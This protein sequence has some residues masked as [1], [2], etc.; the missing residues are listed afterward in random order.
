MLCWVYATVDRANEEMG[1]LGF[2]NIGLPE[3]VCMKVVVTEEVTEVVTDYCLPVAEYGVIWH[4]LLC[5]SD[6]LE[7][8]E[9]AVLGERDDSDMECSRSKALEQRRR[10]REDL[11]DGSRGVRNNL[12]YARI[13]DFVL[14]ACTY[15]AFQYIQY[16]SLY[17][18]KT[19]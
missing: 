9:E 6:E 15:S 19:L 10:R 11:L 1:W 14:Y 16:Y 7:S 5:G 8:Y 17:F 12:P 2:P 18:Y 4:T 3:L 13:Y